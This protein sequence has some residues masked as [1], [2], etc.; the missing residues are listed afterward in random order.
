MRFRR[1][2]PL[3]MLALSL[4]FAFPSSAQ[5][6]HL[7][8]EQISSLAQSGMGDDSGAALITQRGIDFTPTEEFLKGLKAAGA[9]DSFIKALRA[10]TP[11]EPISP[12][13]PLHQ[14]QI[15]AL[16]G[17]GVPT[18]RVTIL[19]KDHGI[20]FKPTKEYLD[21][22]RLGGGDEG[23]INALK[24][25]KVIDPIPVGVVEATGMLE[26]QAG[27]PNAIVYSDN[28]VRGNTDAQ[29]VFSGK[30][31]AGA[32]QIRVEKIGYDTPPEQHI[33]IA[34][35]AALH[36][37]FNLVPQ[38]AKLDLRG[39][40]AGVE[41][42]L[43]STSLGR[44]VESAPFTASVPVGEQNL[45][46]VQ[47]AA[48]RRVTQQ[49]TPGQTLVVQWQSVAP[50]PLTPEELESQDWDQVRSA[51]EST[52]LEQFLSRYPNGLHAAEAQAKLQE[53]AWASI[54]QD[55]LDSLQAYLNRFPN[56]PHSGQAFRLIDDIWWSKVDQKD[57]R[58]LSSFIAE[59]PNSP[60]GSAAQSMLNQIEKAQEEAKH[61]SAAAGT[62]MITAVL[63][64]FNAAFEHKQPREI[65]Q[66][67]PAIPDRYIEANTLNGS[68]FV[69][70][71]HPTGQAEIDGD[72]ASIPGQMV[73]RSAIPGGKP[74]QT[75]KSVT[76]Y[77]SHKTTDHWI[78][79]NILAPI[80]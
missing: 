16:L 48:I 12:K 23:L 3:F 66:V 46:I 44:T 62:Q 11:P 30:L 77:L 40:P 52:P 15:L 33:D 45:L 63:E 27:L 56:G 28:L 57:T 61:P 24:T 79:V 14:V 74:S 10:A 18:Y 60:H 22:I 17:G 31:E 4:A 2:L 65:K 6:K 59:H 19:V 64:Q 36:L 32:H 38:A 50:P 5:Q 55:N 13:K 25:A 20:N 21:E 68:T 73:I 29:G 7:T 42:R 69:M 54:H 76:V 9:T 41:I 47:G 71:L 37:T 67:W 58:A 51:S 72:A 70:A 78:I 80:R 39:A 49:F 35:D 8:Q 34:K 1:S 53:I 75:Q 26:V 43:G